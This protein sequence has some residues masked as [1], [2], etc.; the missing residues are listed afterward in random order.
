MEKFGRLHKKS[1]I[2]VTRNARAVGTKIAL[3]ESEYKNAHD[4]V[5]NTGQSLM[6]EGK[7][8]TEIA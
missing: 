7:D 2:M 5:T 8:V 6:D 3:M 4:F 1:G